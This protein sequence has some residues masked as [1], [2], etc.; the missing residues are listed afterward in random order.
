MA[1]CIYF[2]TAMYA[3]FY[4]LAFLYDWDGIYALPYDAVPDLMYM[5]LGP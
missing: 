5:H 2:I 4:N 1:F 3:K